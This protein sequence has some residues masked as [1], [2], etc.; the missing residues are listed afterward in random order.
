MSAPDLIAALGPV[1]AA[2]EKLRVPYS[3]AG[4]VA[5]SVHGVARAT[6]DVDVV[7]DLQ[8]QHVEPLVA[9]LADAYY[10]DRSAAATAVATRRM[11]NAI[12]L[13]TMMKVDIY[14]LSHRAYDREAFGRRGRAALEDRPDAAHYSLDTP[15]DTILHKLEWY[16]AGG[17]VSE[18]QWRDVQ[19][20]LKVQADALYLAY[21]QHWASELGI[22]QILERALN[23]SSD[24]SRESK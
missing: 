3:L 6:L 21:L 2:L 13:A 8:A 22:G 5:S 24:R 20:I 14:V 15:E 23:E 9:A 4:S 19:G 16:H 11:F 12:H 17:E 7:A 1:V 18:R 10:V